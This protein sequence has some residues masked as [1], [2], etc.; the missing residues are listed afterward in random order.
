MRVDFNFGTGMQAYKQRFGGSEVAVKRL[1]VPLTLQGRTYY[2]A[3]T[4]R[5]LSRVSMKSCSPKKPVKT[6]VRTV[7]QQ[8]NLPVGEANR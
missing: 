1:M 7:I 6:K 8:T 4:A 3:K 2:L 5:D